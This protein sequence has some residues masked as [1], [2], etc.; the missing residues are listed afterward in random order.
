MRR[1]LLIARVDLVRRVRNRSAL[2]TAFAAP[3][4]MAAVFSVLVGGGSQ[5]FSIAVVDAD[6]SPLSRSIVG[7]LVDPTRTVDPDDP[8]DF[9][10]APDEESARR[11]VDEGNVDAALVVPAGFGDEVAAGSPVSLTVLRTPGRLVSGQI[12]ASVAQDI[13]RRFDTVAAAARLAAGEAGGVPSDAVVAAAERADPALAVVGVPPGGEELSPAAFFGASMSLLFLFFTVG[14]AGQSLVGERRTGTVSRI[15]ATPTPPGALIAGK[16]LAVSALGLGGFVT[17]WAA[18]SVVFGARWGPPAV[19][20]AVMVATVVAV[21][22]VSMMVT[23]LARTE[24]QAEAYASAV[25]FV[26][27]LL[28]GNFIGPGP[29]PDLLRRLSLFTPNGWSLRAFTDLGAD[30]ASAGSVLLCIGVLLG[31][32]VLTGTVAVTRIDQLVRS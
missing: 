17:V 16:T 3:L 6:Q 13:A 29:A 27:A 10:A 4:A 30:A 14:F 24:R 7:G 19:V 1:A 32:G 11:S 21:A 5:S 9:E 12:A 25:T 18:T 8:V 20:L 28:G 26:L 23:A 2:I 31:I 22:G 15:L